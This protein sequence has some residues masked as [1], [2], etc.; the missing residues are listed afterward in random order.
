MEY[1]ADS[2]I[3]ITA[4]GAGGTATPALAC[5]ISDTSTAEWYYPDSSVIPVG[6][7]S[8]DIYSN[9]QDTAITIHRPTTATSPTGLYCCG[10]PIVPVD[11]RLCITLCK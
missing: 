3:L 11:Q 4:V 7:S 5:F 1:P 9:R 10:S 8:S 6:F 2:A